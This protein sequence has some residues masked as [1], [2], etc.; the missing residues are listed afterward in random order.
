MKSKNINIV[1]EF[2]RHQSKGE[3]ELALKHISDNAVWHTDSIEAPWSGVHQ[4]KPEIINHFKNIKAS[5]LSFSKTTFDISGSDN[6]AL[7]YEYGLLKCQFAHNNQHFESHIVSIYEI[8]MDKIHSYRVLEN[9]LALHD[10]Y[11]KLNG[12]EL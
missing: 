3:L 7:V 5:V 4:G 9:S 8:K 2:L 12:Q 1:K 11:H 10:S 6:H